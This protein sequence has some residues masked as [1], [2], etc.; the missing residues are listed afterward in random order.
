MRA[1]RSREK[2]QRKRRWS[3]LVLGLLILGLAAWVNLPL[4]RVFNQNVR[5][6]AALPA[7]PAFQRGQRILILAPHPDDE[8]L[9]CGGIIQQ[10][11]AAGATVYVAWMTAGDGFEFDAALTERTLH[12]GAKNMRELGDTRVQEARQAVR[13]LGVPATRTFMLG[14]PDGGLFQLFT[15]NYLQPYTAPRTQARAVYVQGALAPGHAF[16]GRNLEADIG[17]VLSRVNADVVLAPAP[18]DFHPDHHTL[19]YLALRL[20]A[21]RGQGERL[22][23]WVVHGGLEW[24]IPKG[25]HQDLALT[26]PPRAAHLPWERVDLS[27][28]EEQVKLQAINAYRTQTEIMGRFLRAFVRKNELVSPAALPDSTP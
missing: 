1:R 28:Q 18:Q 5:R 3:L 22:R 7:A 13:L 19:T 15:T 17:T 16:T 9:C 10:A 8:T 4:T 12:P 26:L 23:F 6:V 24:P 2:M 14:Y 11:Q 27:A 21:A 20:M 25:L